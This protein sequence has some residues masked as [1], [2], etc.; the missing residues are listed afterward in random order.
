MTTNSPKQQSP[1]VADAMS[2][3]DK[4]GLWANSVQQAL[5]DLKATRAAAAPSGADGALTELATLSRQYTGVPETLRQLR[6]DMV[7]ARARLADI[8]AD[9]S[10]ETARAMLDIAMMVDEKGKPIHSNEA[11]RKAAVEVKLA[12]SELPG[13]RRNEQAAIASIETEIQYNLDLLAE[14]GRRNHALVAIVEYATKT[15]GEK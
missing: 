13:Q 5:E 1:T 7:A 3:I 6:A 2:R 10:Q 15:L 14:Y 4:M 12:D 11:A 8:E 9:A